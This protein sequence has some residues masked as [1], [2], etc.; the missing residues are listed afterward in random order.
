M[1][2]AQQIRLLKTCSALGV[3]PQPPFLFFSCIPFFGLLPCWE[4]ANNSGFVSLPVLVSMTR[5]DSGNGHIPASTGNAIPQYRYQ[6]LP[7]S[8]QRSSAKQRTHRKLQA[9]LYILLL[10]VEYLLF[11]CFFTGHLLVFTRTQFLCKGHFPEA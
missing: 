9:H 8:P 11:K 3:T 1:P 5:G 2:G 6:L 10:H 4:T 7:T